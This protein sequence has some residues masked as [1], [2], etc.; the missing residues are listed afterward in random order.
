[1]LGKIVRLV[2]GNP[3][4]KVLEGLSGDVVQINALEDRFEKLE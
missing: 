4:Q 2:G 3:H 1:M